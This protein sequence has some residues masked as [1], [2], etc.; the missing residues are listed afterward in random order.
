MEV[1][2]YNLNFL[3]IPESWCKS[4]SVTLLQKQLEDLQKHHSQWIDRTTIEATSIYALYAKNFQ[5]EIDEFPSMGFVDCLLG[6][7]WLLATG[8]NPLSLASMYTSN[9]GGLFSDKF[10]GIDVVVNRIER[11]NFRKELSGTIGPSKTLKASRYLGEHSLRQAFEDP[12]TSDFLDELLKLKSRYFRQYISALIGR[13][14][15]EIFC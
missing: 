2:L 7:Q 1:G 9:T 11:E 13:D 6:K 5:D 8:K 14:A 10:P 4:S 3:F 15:F 12:D